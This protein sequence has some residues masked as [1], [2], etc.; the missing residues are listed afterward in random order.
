MEG[1]RME[2]IY[3]TITVGVYLFNQ[4][5]QRRT[6]Y[7]FY[8]PL[9]MTSLMLMV[10]FYFNEE[11]LIAYQDNTEIL[12][13]LITPATVALAIPLYKHRD[14]I[15]NNIKPL[16]IGIFGAVL[17][18]GVV[19]AVL[20]KL[21][22]LN[23]TL[24]ASLTPKSVTTAIAK[25]IAF[26]LGGEPNITIPVVIITGILGSILSESLRSI[27]KIRS[28]AAHGLALGSSAHAMGTSKALEEG[29]IEGVYASIALVLTGLATVALSPLIYTI[30]T[31]L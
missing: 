3:L 30:I 24:I 10:L 22:S 20:S 29:E 4:E 15:K 28:D 5:I 11:Q 19:L 6:K 12:T 25:E 13:L 1:F 23:N 31:K 8:N 17:S 9:L 18:H 14:T 2:L 26:N 16:T 21:L 7:K 27:L